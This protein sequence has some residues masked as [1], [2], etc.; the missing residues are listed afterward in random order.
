MLAMESTRA[1]K[2]PDPLTCLSEIVGDRESRQDTISQ[3]EVPSMQHWPAEGRKLEPQWEEAA[4]RECR[5]MLNPFYSRKRD[6]RRRLSEGPFTKAAGKF[7]FT[8]YSELL[9]IYFWKGSNFPLNWAADSGGSTQ[10]W[11]QWE[12]SADFLPARLIKREKAFLRAERCSGRVLGA[13]TAATQYGERQ[14]VVQL[15]KSERLTES[16]CKQ[17]FS[18]WGVPPFLFTLVKFTVHLLQGLLHIAS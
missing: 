2:A 13:R 5:A 9:I 4:A 7:F 17:H 15:C 6:Q 18:R 8:I 10:R 12:E 3:Q 11:E 16:Q 14:E 1:K